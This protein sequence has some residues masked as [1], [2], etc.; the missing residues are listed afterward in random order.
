MRRSSISAEDMKHSELLSLLALCSA[1]AVTVLSAPVDNT[2]YQIYRDECKREATFKLAHRNKVL[3][4]QRFLKL[5]IKA[6]KQ[7]SLSFCARECT[8]V[9]WCK[10]FNYKVNKATTN[11][12]LLGFNVSDFGAVLVVEP[13]WKHYEPVPSVSNHE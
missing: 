12:Q 3:A 8:S 2:T 10:A 11:C 4:L 13:G 1:L 5:P 6:S 9:S 7:N